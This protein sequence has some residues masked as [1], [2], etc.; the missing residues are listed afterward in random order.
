[1]R[2]LHFINLRAT[3][4]VVVGFVAVFKMGIDLCIIVLTLAIFY[5]I[6]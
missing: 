6:M 1:V 3:E 4:Y 5:F 2:N